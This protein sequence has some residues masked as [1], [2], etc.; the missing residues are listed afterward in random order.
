[1]KR[2][3]NLCGRN[4]GALSALSF[5]A[6]QI[7]LFVQSVDEL[8]S[9]LDV[10]AEHLFVLSDAVHVADPPSQIP[11]HARRQFAVSELLRKKSGAKP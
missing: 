7:A 1:M 9:Q 11:V 8:G 6:P 10:V 4:L 5:A 2:N 3:L